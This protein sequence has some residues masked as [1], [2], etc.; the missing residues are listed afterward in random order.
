MLSNCIKKYKDNGYDIVE[1]KLGWSPI[2]KINK[3]K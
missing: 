2:M 1:R 3:K